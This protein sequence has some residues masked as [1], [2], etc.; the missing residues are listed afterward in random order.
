MQLIRGCKSI[1]NF[2]NSAYMCSS[3][4]NSSD[5]HDP[6]W[7]VWRI[8]KLP[9]LKPGHLQRIYTNFLNYTYCS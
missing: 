5:R 9:R 6:K 8:I 2:Y 1:S 7:Q 3:T 4:A